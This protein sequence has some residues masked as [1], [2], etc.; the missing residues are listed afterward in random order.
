MNSLKSAFR[1]Y[2]RLAGVVLLFLAALTGGIGSARA[3]ALGNGQVVYGTIAGTATTA[4]TFT[5]T[6]GSYI[7]SIW[8]SAG[9]STTSNAEF[10]LTRPNGTKT[11]YYS[12]LNYYY[13]LAGAVGLLPGT[14]TVTITNQES[15]MTA[16]SYGLRVATLPGTVGIPNGQ[17]GGAMQPSVTYS[18]SVSIG[19]FDIWTY[20]GIASKTYSWSL[21]KSS[22]GAGFCPYIQFFR[23]D[24]T[25]SGTTAT[26]TTISSGGG[27][28]AG[29]NYIYISNDYLGNATGSYTLKVSG[30]GVDMTGQG[31]NGDGATC[32]TCAAKQQ[33]PAPQS[34][35]VTAIGAVSTPPK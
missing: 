31:G 24:G 16:A 34:A 1:S 33:G 21:T 28:L 4:Y 14:Y 2:G 29:T 9:H 13:P 20:Q 15:S 8:E 7:I 23:P 35:E 19:A 22:G 18:D 27:T 17:A 6:S 12:D 10:Q 32:L 11:G 3:T 26:C 25:T 30:T 5:A